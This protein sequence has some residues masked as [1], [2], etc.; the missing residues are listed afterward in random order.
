MAVGQTA[1]RFL[2]KFGFCLAILLTSVAG[3]WLLLVL[4]RNDS[5]VYLAKYF[6][7]FLSVNGLLV[8]LCLLLNH[9]VYK[10][11]GG[12]RKEK[13]RKINPR[14]TSLSLSVNLYSGLGGEARLLWDL[15]SDKIAGPAWRMGGGGQ[16]ECVGMDLT[17]YIILVISGWEWWLAFCSESWWSPLLG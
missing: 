9:L 3:G 17:G 4:S 8:H 7:L 1:M 5:H 13:G 2:T 16:V 6:H 10:R 14:Q 12:E 15:G 11:P